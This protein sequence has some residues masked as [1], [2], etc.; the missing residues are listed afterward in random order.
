MKYL[1]ILFFTMLL[2]YGC[3]YP[4]SGVRVLDKR[5]SI[6][7]QNAPRNATL[8]VDG[9]NMGLANDYN[10]RHRALLV[11]SGTHKI[12]VMYN[13]LP[14]LSEQVFLGSGEMKTFRVH[15]PGEVK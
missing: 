10:V 8:I 2:V 6:V 7:V 9:L 1:I 12:E 15:T 14:L 11:E 4:T 13:G 5:P 3:A